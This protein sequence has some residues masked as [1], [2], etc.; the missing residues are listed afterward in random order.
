MPTN[1]KVIDFKIHNLTEEQFQK[2][3]DAGQ[4]EPNALYC[5]PDETAA[6]FEEL[7][8]RINTKQDIA[9]AVNYDN[10]TN[11]ITE[12]PQDIKL[13][14][15]NG[16]LTLKAGSKVYV[17][18][19]AGVFDIE[20]VNVDIPFSLSTNNTYM[21]FKQQGQNAIDYVPVTRTLCDPNIGI[22]DGYGD[23]AVAYNTEPNSC[24]LYENDGKSNYN[25][26]RNESLPICVF[27]VSN[28]TISSIDHVFNGF[29]YI[30]STVF[31]LPGVKGLIP[32]G[33]NADGSL[34]NIEVAVNN[35]AINDTRQRGNDTGTLS[36]AGKI[37]SWDTASLFTDYYPAPATGSWWL[38]Y[39]T[40]KNVYF[41]SDDGGAYFEVRRTPFGNWR[42][43]GNKIT[44]FTPKTAF[45]AV[46][47]NDLTDITTIASPAG[48]VSA[49][50]GTSAPSGWLKCDGSAISRTL[51]ADLFAAIGTKYGSGDGSTTFN[52]P[53][54]SVLPLGTSAPVY[55]N[56]AQHTGVLRDASTGQAISDLTNQQTVQTT[57][58]GLTG[59]AETGV[60][61]ID[62][63]GGV[64]TRWTNY[65]PNGTLAVNLSQATG[66]Q[67]IACIKY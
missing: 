64:Q 45:R 58:M 41:Q 21:L 35:V 48:M 47:Y 51:Y 30:G 32:D 19:G 20:T 34:K 9:T 46:D 56:G 6:N 2:L 26:I 18:N 28:G 22:P 60:G 12:I 10:I 67:A 36:I 44:N 25:L 16:V 63:L 27:T 66:A 52:L 65:D 53:T 5:T 50:A 8:A 24:G 29:G 11:C 49:F 15:A 38:V 1:R 3:K 61:Y 37:S 33:R 17:P 62:K 42:K 55:N 57:N 31:A 23:Y 59:Y 7:R 54:Q 13:E 40:K 43:E 14:L 4:I 39:D